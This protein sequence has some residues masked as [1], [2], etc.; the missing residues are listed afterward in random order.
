MSLGS[1]SL[2]FEAVW[3]MQCGYIL[4][5]LPGYE[6]EDKWCSACHEPLAPYLVFKP[7]VV[8]AE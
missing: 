5:W 6:P 4:R 7:K 3:C 2:D 1:V 8:R